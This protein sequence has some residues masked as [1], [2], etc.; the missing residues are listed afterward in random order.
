MSKRIGARARV[1]TT[2]HHSRFVNDV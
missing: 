1:Q 2:Y